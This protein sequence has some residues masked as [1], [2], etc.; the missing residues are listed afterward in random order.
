MRTIIAKFC[1]IVFTLK[2][3]CFLIHY[4]LWFIMWGHLQISIGTPPQK[5]KVVFDTGSSNLWVPSKNCKFTNIACLTHNKYNAK[6]SSTYKPN[7]TEFEIRYGSGSLSGYLST[8]VLEVKNRHVKICRVCMCE[9]H[10]I[11]FSLS[12]LLPVALLT[13]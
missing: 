11:I 10:L 8:D 9:P 6:A 1:Q 7:N 2:L 13:I 4:S 5:F 12:F 3:I